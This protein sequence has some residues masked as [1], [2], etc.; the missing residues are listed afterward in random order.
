MADVSKVKDIQ[1][2]TDT[3]VAPDGPAQ[4]RPKPL[5]IPPPTRPTTTEETD[6][7]KNK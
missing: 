5:I 4:E 2:N 7:P 6:K 3:L 1:W